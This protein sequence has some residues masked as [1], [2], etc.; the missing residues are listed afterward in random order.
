MT[1]RVIH[2]FFH[3]RNRHKMI[4]PL[5]RINFTIQRKNSHLVNVISVFF[6]IRLT[7]RNKLIVDENRH[8]QS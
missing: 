1:D 7:E 3:F 6:R 8:F 5:Q 4:F 2:N